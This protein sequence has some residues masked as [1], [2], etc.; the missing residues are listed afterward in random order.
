MIEDKD[1][2]S[3]QEVRA[4]VDKAWTAWQS[5]RSFNQQQV[6]AIVEAM[7]SAAR[8]ASLRLA[9]ICGVRT[10]APGTQNTATAAICIQCP[11]Y[12]DRCGLQ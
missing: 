6:D 7:A 4:K 3:I 5:Y 2:L 10:F 8:S 12:I 1:L 11:C 9:E